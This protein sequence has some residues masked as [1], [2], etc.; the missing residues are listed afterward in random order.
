MTLNEYVTS[1]EKLGLSRRALSWL[2]FLSIA[3]T[4]AETIGLS[5][6]VPI[7]DFISVNGDLSRVAESGYWQILFALSS[8][9]GVDIGLGLLLILAFTA[10]LFRQFGSYVRQ[11]TIAQSREKVSKQVRVE[12]FKNY[13]QANLAAQEDL[14]AGELVNVIT[15]ELQRFN[16]SLM[17]L[18]ALFNAS[19][20]ILV[21]GVFLSW[22]SWQMA[23]FSFSAV[24]FAVVPIR[25]IYRRTVDAGKEATRA[26]IQATNFFVERLNPAR[27]IRLSRSEFAEVKRMDSF[28]SDQRKTML[29]LERLMALTAVVIEPI[30]LG[31]MFCLIYVATSFLQVPMAS[32]GV[33]LLVILRLLP[34]AKDALKGRQIISA[35]AASTSA[36]LTALNRLKH[37]V[38][39]K[40][41]AEHFS[42][43]KTT[44]RFSDTGFSY[45]NSNQSAL[46]GVNLSISAGS[47]VAILGPSGAGKSTL[48][49][50]LPA[51]RIPTSGAIYMDG[52]PLSDFS[53]SSLRKSI[54]Y[55]PQYPEIYDITVAEHVCLGT[56]SV[57]A[58]EIEDALSL[59]GAEAFVSQMPKG[60]HSRLGQTGLNLS[61]GQRQRLDIARAIV[62]KSS[63][64]ILDE[65]TS[66]LDAASEKSLISMLKFLCSKHGL[67]IIVVTHRLALV[68]DANQIIVMRDG[69]V[70]TSG[71]LEEARKNSAWFESALSSQFDKNDRATKG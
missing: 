62:S 30:T 61:G 68:N 20:L 70:E 35:S 34:V 11:M 55:V 26:N 21:Y 43:V 37:S 8:K 28:T 45:L 1:A 22:T 42:G 25:V 32:L 60:I 49:D 58:K 33:F 48:I 3:T 23:A 69:S 17:G 71:S 50:L 40:G 29:G 19:V 15:N 31:L 47:L 53:H 16:A 51:L 10:V 14:K 6:V 44:I 9:L 59:V 67:T 57:N 36:L 4:I 56:E 63:V 41:G 46:K 52:K 24:L 38:E 64:M 65:P 27:L 2:M 39:G 66:A 54:A 13:L 12:I 5:M 18:V 7:Y